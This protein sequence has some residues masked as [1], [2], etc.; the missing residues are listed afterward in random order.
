MG[1]PGTCC[2]SLTLLLLVSDDKASADL[3]V[4]NSCTVKNPA[5]DHF[6]NDIKDARA[7]NKYLVLAGCVPQ[8]QPRGDYM[9]VCTC[10]VVMVLTC[11]VVMVLTCSS[12]LLYNLECFSVAIHAS[13]GSGVN[14][15]E[16][17]SLKGNTYIYY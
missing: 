13:C 8:G 11:S 4:L 14:L 6:R 9:Q 2:V 15:E 17:L 12:A 7:M 5:E 3:W 1:E 10:S 16:S